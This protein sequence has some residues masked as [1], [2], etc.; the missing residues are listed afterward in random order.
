M[1]NHLTYVRPEL[2]V[3]AKWALLAQKAGLNPG[4][5]WEN[6]VFARQ[7]EAVESALEAQADM[8]ARLRNRGG[9]R[10]SF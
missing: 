1:S 3:V 7:L 10:K 6:T 9:P 4:E 5:S 8:I 2:L